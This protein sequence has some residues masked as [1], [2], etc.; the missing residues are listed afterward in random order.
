M[1][2]IQNALPHHRYLPRQNTLKFHHQ[3]F[4]SPR[5]LLYPNPTGS[6]PPPITPAKT[7][8]P[9][10]PAMATTLDPLED[11]NL[12]IPSLTTEFLPTPPACLQFSPLDT[13]LLLIG[14]YHLQ[15]GVRSGTLEL[16]RNAPVDK[17][18]HL[19]SHPTVGGA[20]LD[21]KFNP[22]NP[23]EFAIATS[24]GSVGI[25]TLHTETETEETPSIKEV[26]ILNLFD[27]ET[28]VTSLNYS[29][30]TPNIIAATLTDGSVAVIDTEAKE[31][32]TQWTPHT[33]E[34]WTCEWSPDGTVVYSGGDDA[35]FVGFHVESETEIGRAKRGSHGAGVTAI[36]DRTKNMAGDNYA[37]VWTGSYDDTVRIWDLRERRGWMRPVQESNLGGGVWRLQ[38]TE[39]NE[40]LASCMHA[41]ARLLKGTGEGEERL[42][43]V[44]R[45]EE[46]ESMNY[47]GDVKGNKVASCSFYD[48]RVV[49]WNI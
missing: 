31:I 29:P 33:L 25:Y 23:S 7:P 13:S 8:S 3:Q 17:L 24:L 21:L 41:G 46:N 38:E 48:K 26:A 35:G 9:A 45:W 28:L 34:C 49:I 6:Q 4:A 16:Y 39:R 22:H 11:P 40:V 10:S 14:T 47:G 30:T 19:Q 5:R 12:L 32:K 42:E 2:Y 15:E 1:T 18:S 36:L 27:P 44:K 37:G 43:V 20:V